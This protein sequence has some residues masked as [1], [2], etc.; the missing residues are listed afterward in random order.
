[1]YAREING[2]EF[3]FGVSGKL[4]RNV[5]VMYDRQTESYWSQLLG[6][7]VAG[8]MEGTKLDFVPSWMMTWQEWKERHPDTVALDKGGRRGGRDSYAGYYSSDSAGVIGETFQDDRLYTKEFV[9]GV[10]VGEEAAAY[11][12]SVLNAEPVINDIVADQSILVVFDRDSAVSVVYD[13]VVDG[14][15]LTFTAVSEEAAV[16]SSRLTDA[17]T[18]TTW[19]K[20][21]GEALDGPLSGERLQRLKSTVVFWFGWKDFYP[22]TLVYGLEE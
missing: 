17:E 7:A 11:P 15:A 19:D 9:V 5:L 14:Q 21:S 18:G 20:L 16:S 1:M 22:D 12:F 10:A 2:E 4:I 6:E 8:E 13:R 3:T